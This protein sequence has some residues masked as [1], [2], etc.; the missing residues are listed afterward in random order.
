MRHH[1]RGGRW[2]GALLGLM[3]MALVVA[4]CQQT[5]N[6]PEVAGIVASREFV[7]GGATHYV[8]TDGRDLT[9]DLTRGNPVIY[10]TAGPAVGELLLSGSGPNG[11]WIARLTLA[12]WQ[13][14]PSGCYTV[15]GFGTDRGQWIE[16]DAGLRLPKAKGFT[17]TEERGDRFESSFPVFCLDETGQ[18]TS[19]R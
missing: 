5:F 16:T 9:I 17:T 7:A 18:V 3:P 2:P 14:A 15:S 19:F 4:G 11:Q 12:S 13:D 6:T 8:L 10:G 1:E